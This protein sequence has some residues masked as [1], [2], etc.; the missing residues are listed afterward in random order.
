VNINIVYE[1]KNFYFYFN[2]VTSGQRGR[3]GKIKN[4]ANMAG[5]EHTTENL[6]F[7]FYFHLDGNVGGAAERTPVEI[8]VKRLEWS[9][10]AA[11]GCVVECV[12]RD[13]PVF[14]D[15]GW[16]PAV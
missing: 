15:G 9:R 1:R 4:T 5:E 3:K 2:G 10:W 16:G 11:A 6:F 14:W 12:V 7:F 13:G 8:W